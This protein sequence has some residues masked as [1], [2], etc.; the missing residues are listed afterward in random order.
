MFIKRKKHGD[1]SPC[2]F[3][4]QLSAHIRQAGTM[5]TLIDKPRR[6]EQ[7]PSLAS[8]QPLAGSRHTNNDLPL[9]TALLIIVER[10]YRIVE[11][12][13]PVNDRHNLARLN[14]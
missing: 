13:L 4:L 12:E 10:F 1:R 3:L 8:I 6:T 14:E 5:L 2:F 9:H 7:L 11:C